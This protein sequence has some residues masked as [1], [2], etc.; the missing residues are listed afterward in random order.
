M[1]TVAEE[2]AEAVRALRARARALIEAQGVQRPVLAQILD[3]LER[4]AAR[5]PLWSEEDYP[6]PEEGERQARYL[7]AVDDD[8]TCAL[9]LNVMRP[10]KLI[11]PHDHTTWACIAAVEGEE[12]NYLYERLDD[13]RTPGRATIRR[14]GHVTVGPGTG[15]AL[16]PDDI[17]AVEI[18]GDRIIR[19][20][21]MYG[22]ALEV[23]DQ[24]LTF[25]PENGTC[26]I[27]DIGVKTRRA[28]S[29]GA[30]DR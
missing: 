25:D 4:V 5:R 16:L 18:T 2:R 11:P 27:M 10:G 22:R 3:E 24:R 20:L 29:A 1:A 6:P 26:R 23:L 17:H 13:G 15:V 12:Q 8:Q 14:T 7:V 19:H 30:P 9:Y 21:H 28:P